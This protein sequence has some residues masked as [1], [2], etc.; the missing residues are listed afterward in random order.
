VIAED[1][2][3]INDQD[4]RNQ[5]PDHRQAAHSQPGANSPDSR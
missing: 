4:Q 1:A 5:H 3:G 2:Q